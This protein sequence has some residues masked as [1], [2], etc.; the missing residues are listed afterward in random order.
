MRLRLQF[1]LFLLAL[2]CSGCHRAP[3]AMEAP[4]VIVIDL[5]KRIET[6]RSGYQA[7]PGGVARRCQPSGAAPG[8]TEPNATA[9]KV[10]MV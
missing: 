9:H 3:D 5:A 7:G 4:C 1:G 10:A 8:E 2:L 6:Q